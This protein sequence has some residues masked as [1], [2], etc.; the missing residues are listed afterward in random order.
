MIRDMIKNIVDRFW[1]KVD[2]TSSTTFYKNTRCWN[3]VATLKSTGY[4]SFWYSGKMVSSHRFTYK[5]KH[6][7]IPKG[8]ELD[9]LCRN[10]K[11][12]NPNH[13][14]TVTHQENM[15][16]GFS[17]NGHKTHCIHGHKFTKENTY[18][19]KLPNNTTWR[20]CKK[21]GIIRCQ[22]RYSEKMRAI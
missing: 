7:K 5:L 10:R 19:Y 9:H 1:S 18:L 4:G 11:C 21:C 8:L 16:R 17:F 2:K 12:C 15:Q 6:G 22:K 3:W 14:E 20:I 13:L